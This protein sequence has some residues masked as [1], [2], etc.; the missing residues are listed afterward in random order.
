MG[1]SP[2]IWFVLV[3]LI[4]LALG[5]VSA[6]LVAKATTVPVPDVT[7]SFIASRCESCSISVLVLNPATAV[8]LNSEFD[9]ALSHALRNLAVPCAELQRRGIC[10]RKA[11]CADKPT[12]GRQCSCPL[13]FGAPGPAG[14]IRCA[15]LCALA[16]TQPV[17]LEGSGTPLS[18]DRSVVD[19]TAHLDF[20]GFAKAGSIDPS[21]AT[22]WLVPKEGVRSASLA[23]TAD[24]VQTGSTRTGSYELQL[25][26]HSEICTLVGTLDVRCTPGYSAADAEGMPCMPVVNITAAGIRI[27]SSAGEVVF[28]GQLR[29]ADLDSKKPRNYAFAPINAG[30]Q[31]TVEV[32]VRDIHGMLVNRST[33]GLSMVLKGKKTASK[34]APFKPPTGS[35]S[36]FFVLTVPEMWIPEPDTIES[37]F[38]LLQSQFARRFLGRMLDV[39]SPVRASFRV[40]LNVPHCAKCSF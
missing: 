22:V 35:R 36:G 16:K 33:L 7:V 21:A 25:R 19:D 11:V 4:W 31:L 8:I 3:S 28:D 34:E 13:G 38:Q 10:D 20:S 30:D 17:Y 14:E 40:T 5:L 32:T 1:E 12:G 2:R 37:A 6:G 39:R 18:V 27:R 24:L 29:T 23:N 26:S 9:P 15:D